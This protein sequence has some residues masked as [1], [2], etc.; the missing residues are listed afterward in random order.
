MTR[1][2]H[3][4]IQTA[5][6]LEAVGVKLAA[7][8]K[9]VWKEEAE[10]AARA[11]ARQAAAVEAI[12]RFCGGLLEGS[13]SDDA[14]PDCVVGLASASPQPLAEHLVLCK[15]MIVAYPGNFSAIRS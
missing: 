4:R 13:A 5:S 3:A 8:L 11:A 2:R 14:T 10:A 9:R 6:V 15:S 12:R 1:P 7:A